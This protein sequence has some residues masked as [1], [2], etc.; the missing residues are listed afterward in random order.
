MTKCVVSPTQETVMH[1]RIHRSRKAAASAYVYND[2]YKSLSSPLFPVLPSSTSHSLHTHYPHPPSTKLKHTARL[3]FTTVT[4][5]LHR[6][7]VWVDEQGQRR[8][9]WREEHSRGRCIQPRPQ[10]YDNI[11]DISLIY[12]CYSNVSLTFPRRIWTWTYHY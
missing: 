11:H 10:R 12:Y 5:Y 7:H 1:H 8:S 6:N 2:G 9:H 3:K 4:I